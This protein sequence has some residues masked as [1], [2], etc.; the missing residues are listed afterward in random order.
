M[1]EPK[2]NDQ[3]FSFNK[4]L[5]FNKS[6]NSITDNYDIIKQISKGENEIIYKLKNIKTGK[7][8]SCKKISKI[9]NKKQDKIIKEVNILSKIDH[10]NIINTYEIYETKNDLFTITEYC[11]GNDLFSFINENK[12]LLSEK[13]ILELFLQI[14]SAINYC[15]NYNL[16]YMN[17]NPENIFFFSENAKENNHIKLI[18]FELKQIKENQK[19]KVKNLSSYYMAPEILTG[20]FGLNCDIWSAGIILY[21]LLSGE[22]PFKKIDDSSMNSNNIKINYS[23]NNNKWYNISKE[24]KDLIKCMLLPADKRINI[25]QI[26]SHNW[27]QKV[28]KHIFR[29]L[30]FNISLFSKYKYSLLLKK[31]ILT[32]ISSR[33]DMSDINWIVKLFK[34]FDANNNGQITLNNFKQSMSEL[35]KNNEYNNKGQNTNIENELN[36]IFDSIDTDKNG[37]IEFTEFIASLLPEN[38][39]SNKYILY[40]SFLYFSQNKKKIA[41]KDLY[42]LLKIDLNKNKEINNNFQL[43]DRNHDGCIDFNEY[44]ELMGIK[45]DIT[46]SERKHK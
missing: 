24:A 36:F 28:N 39:Y 1:D 20:E 7:F 10:P 46:I 35:C 44:I 30:S 41:K 15:H 23:F 31:I 18:N 13:E 14:I 3:G 43:V 42:N 8:F 21:F 40:E 34:F 2:V 27:C 17:L 11:N 38:I 19:I 9:S 16:C 12:K 25:D 22:L 32:Y 29:D 45:I 5:F 6:I 4:N 37:I 26:L 33:I